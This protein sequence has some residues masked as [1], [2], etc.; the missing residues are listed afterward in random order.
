MS[1]IP[2]TEYDSA[3][4]AVKREYDD[5]IAKHGRITNMKRTLL[6]N[7]PSFKAYME[8]YTLYDELKPVLGDRA[9]QIFSYAISNGNDCEICGS[10]FNKILRDNGDDPDDLKLNETEELLYTLGT[11]ISIDPHDIPDFV[12]EGLKA[13]FPDDVIV[14]IFAFAGI[15]YATNLFNTVCKVD[16]DEVLYDYNIMKKKEEKQNG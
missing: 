10:F 15:M 4:E 8:W 5:Q 14:T 16:L 1:Y 12:Y 7:V 3:D 11:A 9:L 2:M 13:K 6:H